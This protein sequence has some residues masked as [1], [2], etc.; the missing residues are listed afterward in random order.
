MDYFLTRIY[1]SAILVMLA[2]ISGMA[3][4]HEQVEAVEASTWYTYNAESTNMTLMLFMVG[5]L[6]A[7]DVATNVQGPH[8]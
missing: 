3:I 1:A 8:G 6:C 2:C 4:A 7:C 5:E